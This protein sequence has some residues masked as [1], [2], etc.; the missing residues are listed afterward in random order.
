MIT[1]SVSEDAE[2]LEIHSFI[3]ENSL[4]LIKLNMYLLCDPV[5]RATMSLLANCLSGS[6]LVVNPEILLRVL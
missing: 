4:V 6:Y 1:V 2:K 3:A 5:P